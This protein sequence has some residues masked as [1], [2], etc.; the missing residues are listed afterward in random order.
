LIHLTSDG[1][2]EGKGDGFIYDIDPLFGVTVSDETGEYGSYMTPLG[3]LGLVQDGHTVA[4][5]SSNGEFFAKSYE[6]RDS[7]T[8][9]IKAHLTNA[10]NL[11][12]PNGAQI[13][14]GGVPIGGGIGDQIEFEDGANSS[15]LD[16]EGL[17]VENGTVSQSIMTGTGIAVGN[18]ANTS[19]VDLQSHGTWEAKQNGVIVSSLQ[20]NGEIHAKSFE[21]RDSLTGAIK[22]H[23][24]NSGGLTATG[25]IS[26]QYVS[27][28]TSVYSQSVN[29]GT[30]LFSDL[31]PGSLRSQTLLNN[32]QQ[33][34]WTFFNNGTMT[35]W[36]DP[37]GASP[38]ILNMSTTSDGYWQFGMP[39][40]FGNPANFNY[41]SGGDLTQGLMVS[42][43]LTVGGK[44]NA[45]GTFDP[46]ICELFPAHPDFEFVPGTVVVADRNS[47]YVMPCKEGSQTGV[48][49]VVTP[50]EKVDDR[51]HIMVTILGYA[52]AFRQDGTRLEMRVKADAKYGAIRRGDLLTTS[53][54]SGHAMLA[55]E[56]KLG[57]IVGKALESLDSGTG[58][59]KVMVTL[60]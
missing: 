57:T 1:V 52:A 3:E 22:A 30:T 31:S 13:T 35:Q 37:P 50:G 5:T 43:N 18:N 21:V 14:I 26:G 28:T 49:G 55:A 15:L 60:Q 19:Y 29:G 56:P 46:I 16:A 58:E 17:F 42:G 9:A 47:D 59:I 33:S 20:L 10:G 36:V 2:I 40:F 45:V 24:T 44:V 54:T 53:A 41:L 39:V 11:E 38:P 4:G 8:G 34:G 48:I 7:L 32:V 23:L 12:L 51:G 6:V 25:T 27:G